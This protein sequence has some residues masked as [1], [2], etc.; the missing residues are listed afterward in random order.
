MDTVII[1]YFSTIF[2]IVVLVLGLLVRHWLD[3]DETD[4]NDDEPYN[5]L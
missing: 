4:D 2:A 1:W 3:D 5:C